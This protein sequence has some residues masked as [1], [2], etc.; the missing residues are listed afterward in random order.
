MLRERVEVS[1]NRGGVLRVSKIDLLGRRIILDS[2][3]SFGY[4]VVRDHFSPSSKVW[5]VRLS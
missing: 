4:D 2:V 3:Q 5:G 1:R